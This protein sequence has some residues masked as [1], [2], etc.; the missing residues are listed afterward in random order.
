MKMINSVFDASLAWDFAIFGIQFQLYFESIGFKKGEFSKR[1]GIYGLH[2][3]WFYFG[4]CTQKLF[5]RTVEEAMLQ[6][7]TQ[8]LNQRSN[9]R[10]GAPAVAPSPIIVRPLTK[11]QKEEL[12]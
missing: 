12:N 3:R 5:K 10:S 7:Y 1:P 9:T 8:H 11:E 4:F 2:L 6:A